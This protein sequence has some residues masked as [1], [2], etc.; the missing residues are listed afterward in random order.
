LKVAPII[1][2][3]FKDFRV[4]VTIR[5]SREGGN[6]EITDEVYVY[7]LGRIAEDYSPAYLDVE[8]FS[9]PKAL[10]ELQP[11]ADKIVLSYH[12]FEKLP[13]DLTE[14]LQRMQIERVALIKVAVSPRT[15][16]EVLALMQYARAFA[17]SYR[18]PLVTIAMG[19]IGTMTRIASPLTASAWTFACLPGEP[20]A[21]GQLTLTETRTIL[22]ILEK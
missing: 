11:F 16:S 15:K 21:P 17:D 18:T 10:E 3:R 19:Q 9:Y 2:E 22:K 8:Y 5:S 6:I 14:R 4:L 12:D 1:F 13:S 20:S 7:L